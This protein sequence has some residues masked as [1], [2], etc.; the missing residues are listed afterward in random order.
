M[1][2]GLINYDHLISGA[3]LPSDMLKK[4]SVENRTMVFIEP[5]GSGISMLKRAWASGFNI[6][7]LTANSGLRKVADTIIESA[8]LAIRIDTMDDECVLKLLQFLRQHTL[9][10]TVIPGFEYFVPLAAY[11]N[12]MLGL[13][14]TNTDLVACLRNKAQM[15][16]KLRQ[17]GIR[18]PR[19]HSVSSLAE[20]EKAIEEIG[21]PGVCKPVDAAGSVNVRKVDNKTAALQA[22][23]RILQGTDVLWGYQL[24]RQLLYEEYIDG[25]EY[26]VEGTV[27]NGHVVFFSVTEKI[28]HDQSEFI[29]IGHIV[30]P[31]LS[32]DMINQIETYVAE[33]ITVLKPDNC[34]FHAEVRITHCGM[35]VLM[36]IAARLAGDKIGELITLSRRVNY[37]D[38][39]CASYLGIN[40]YLSCGHA[41]VAG[42]RFFYRPLINRFSSISGMDKI[43]QSAVEEIHFYYHKNEDI[44][45]FPKPLRRLGHVIMKE[46]NYDRMKTTLKW[47]DDS[48]QFH[49]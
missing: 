39:A 32:S 24:S 47:I 33:V 9:M 14:G 27:T 38:Y 10:D 30:N 42:I 15:R 6:I 16:A 45:S 41:G 4:I 5:Y 3:I 37:F 7:I 8:H 1:T 26:S 19:F 29:E 49:A 43:N 34:P 28:V 36:E 12:A 13:P 17:A 46:S 20:L 21:F 22:A 40:R 48:I 2:I 23:V 31:P 25:Q 18:I 11:A 44:P 35:P